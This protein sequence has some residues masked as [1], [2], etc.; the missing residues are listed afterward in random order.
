[1]DEGSGSKFG[2]PVSEAR[3]P[4][5]QW[6]CHLMQLLTVSG[7][8]SHIP[9]THWSQGLPRT[10]VMRIELAQAQRFGDRPALSAGSVVFAIPRTSVHVCHEADPPLCSKSSSGLSRLQIPCF[11]SNPSS[12]ITTA[13]KCLELFP[14]PIFRVKINQFALPGDLSRPNQS[15]RG[16][17]FKLTASCN[18]P[19]AGFPST[20]GH[21]QI[22]AL[23]LIHKERKGNV[24]AFIH[25]HT[26][27]CPNTVL[28]TYQV[29]SKGLLDQMEWSTI[30]WN[31][32]ELRFRDTEASTTQIPQ[33]K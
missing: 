18:F 14:F 29:F 22:P 25:L 11:L 6:L 24:H 26:P 33:C 1:M 13:L 31:W 28:S 32:I 4:D 15:H 7:Q 3:L 30:E 9:K 16:I 19:R 8:Y 21:G 12:N 23:Q 5:L 2:L 10:V 17:L 20:K 27:D